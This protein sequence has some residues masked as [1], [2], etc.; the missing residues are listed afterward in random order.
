MHAHLVSV[1]EGP[2]PAWLTALGSGYAL[3]QS[4]GLPLAPRLPSWL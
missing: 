2:L 1:V 3:Q 4:E